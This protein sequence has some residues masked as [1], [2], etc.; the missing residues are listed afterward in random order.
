MNHSKATTVTGQ[1]KWAL[2]VTL[3][4]AASTAWAIPKV[5]QAAPAFTAVD[6]NGKTV[7]LKDFAGKKVILEWTNHKC[8]FVVKHYEGNMQALQKQY[9]NEEVVW[10][11][12]ISSAKGKQG[13]VDGAEANQ[14]SADRGAAPDHVLLDPEG[15]LG[16]LYG[17]KTT[18]HMYIVD[19]KGALKYMGAIDSIR[20]TNPTDIPK[21]T[22]YVTQAMVELAAGKAVSEPVTQA[23][24][25]SVKY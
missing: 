15:T 12:V 18:P 23:Y 16:K 9:P 4:L 19:E 25:C 22:N 6:S 7:S 14:L 1:I 3:V 2:W 17:A 8:P 10:L 21:A 5:D 11:S 13:Y 20:S 24:G